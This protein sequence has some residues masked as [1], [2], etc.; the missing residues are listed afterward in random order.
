MLKKAIIVGASSGI[1]AKLI[2]VLVREGYD[3]VALARAEK[4]NWPHKFNPTIRLEGVCGRFHMMFLIQI[5][6]AIPSWR[7]PRYSAASTSWF[8]SRA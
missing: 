6:C 3:V 1:G 4:T 5:P 7:R 2:G 8:M